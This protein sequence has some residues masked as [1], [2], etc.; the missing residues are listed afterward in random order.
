MSER[1]CTYPGCTRRLQARGWCGTHYLRWRKWGDPSIVHKAIPVYPSY[2][3]E[4]FWAKVAK[5]PGCW[6]WQGRID[7]TGYGRCWY[8]GNHAVAHRVAW[9]L[10]NGPIPSGHSGPGRIGVLHHCDNRKCCRPDHLFLGSD[11]DN[12]L[13]RDRKGRR[14][15][16][17][18]SSNSGAKL[19]EE[20]V[21]RIRRQYVWRRFGCDKLATEYGVSRVT[22]NRIV[23]RV[24][25]AH[26]A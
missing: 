6:E 22:I 4:R 20:D 10:T 23:R 16:Q 14:T 2:D 25:W 9:V 11:K 15:A 17:R 19:T 18:G 26:V 24:A 7:D 13:D 5:G 12:A 8:A 21:R 1:S 3:P